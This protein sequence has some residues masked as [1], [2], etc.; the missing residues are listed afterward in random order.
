MGKLTNVIVMSAI[1]P[2]GIHWIA[3]IVLRLHMPQV[4]EMTIGFY[5]FMTAL[6]HEREGLDPENS[7]TDPFVY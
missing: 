3:K 5:N 7:I 4:R 1:K 2:K 6:F